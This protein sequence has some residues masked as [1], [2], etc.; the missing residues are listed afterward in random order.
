MPKYRV[1][2]SQ[3]VVEEHDNIEA[4]SEDDAYAKVKDRE[5]SPEDVQIVE[6]SSEIIEIE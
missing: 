1:I 4:D 3:T 2:L 6:E 5:G